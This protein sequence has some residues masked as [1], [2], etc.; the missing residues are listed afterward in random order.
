V[1]TKVDIY[2]EDFWL[3]RHDELSSRKREL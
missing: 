3:Q 2:H 1:P